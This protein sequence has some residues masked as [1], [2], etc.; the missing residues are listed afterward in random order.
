MKSLKIA[1]AIAL[2]ATTAACGSKNSASPTA[3]AV[4]RTPI[5]WQYL[6]DVR[7]DGSQMAS[8]YSDDALIAL[9]RSVCKDLNA[10]TE[11]VA[12][13]EEKVK[14]VSQEAGVDQLQATE[15]VA[16]YVEKALVNFCPEMQPN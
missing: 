10:G 2:V 13:V 9:G 16:S 4:E 6:T 3:S 11:L 1:I 8:G 7:T 12:V 5:E 15:F 14:N